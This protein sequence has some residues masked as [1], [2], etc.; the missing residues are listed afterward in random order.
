M[1]ACLFY[2][3]SNRETILDIS[4]IHCFID[5]PL[6]PRRTTQ[7]EKENFKL[8]SLVKIISRQIDQIFPRIFY[9]RK[10]VRVSNLCSRGEKKRKNALESS[11]ERI[12]NIPNNHPPP[13]DI[14]RKLALRRAFLAS[15]SPLLARALLSGIK[16]Q[17]SPLCLRIIC[18]RV[19]VRS[20]QN[21][22]SVQRNIVSRAD[23]HTYRGFILGVEA[24]YVAAF[25]TRDNDKIINRCPLEGSLPAER[26]FE[27]RNGIRETRAARIRHIV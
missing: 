18:I 11:I 15:R 7:K 10:K 19:H 4:S 5:A 21:T 1:A 26:Y 13:P 22:R 23:T 8:A 9:Y 2:F 14:N 17:S 16:Y 12:I 20:M 25:G 24:R 6:I 27:A 3:R